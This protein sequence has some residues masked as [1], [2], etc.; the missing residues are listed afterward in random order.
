[1]K[2]FFCCI[3]LELEQRLFLL[4]KNYLKIIIPS[5]KG[6][7][8]I[9]VFTSPQCCCVGLLCCQQ[10]SWI[11]LSRSI[12][13]HGVYYPIMQSFEFKQTISQKIR[14][15]YNPQYGSFPWITYRQWTWINHFAIYSLHC[16]HKMKM[17][18]VDMRKVKS[19]KESYLLL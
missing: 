13:N 8:K 15:M 1:M 5:M 3:L 6:K 11:D 4:K 7:L 12:T 18:V 14:S 19:V 10:S 9:M 2:D 17:Q 16:R